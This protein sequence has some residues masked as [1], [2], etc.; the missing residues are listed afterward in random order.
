VRDLSSGNPDPDLLPELRRL[1][2]LRGRATLYGQQPWLDELFDLARDQL[3]ADGIPVDG[4]T[5]VSGAMDAIERVLAAHLVPGDSVAVED[6]GYSAVLDLLPAMGL[7]SLPVGIDDSGPVPDTLATALRQ[8]AKAL[9]LTPRAQNPTG[10]AFSRER[11]RELAEVV[12]AHPMLVI[13]EDDH[14]GVVSGAPSVSLA[15]TT[16]RWVVIRSVSKWLG[17]DLRL[18]VIAG[19]EVSIGRV[20]GRQ[21]LGPGWVSLLLQQLVVSM[22]SDPSVRELLSRAEAEYSRRRRALI[23]ALSERGVEATG[24][25]GLNVWIPVPEEQPVVA[26]LLARGLAVAAGERFRLTSEPGVRI[27]IGSLRTHDVA[28]VADAVSESTRRSRLA[29]LG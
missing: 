15:G 18:A 24:K 5:V 1:D 29:R 26:G 8:G 11:A 14:A 25:S 9:V 10:A 2:A 4:L 16:I 23:E 13:I 19:D 28:A 21:R 27:S 22:W 12:S 6:P 20:E 17:P 3:S 7:R